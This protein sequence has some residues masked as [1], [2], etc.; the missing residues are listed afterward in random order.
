LKT[1]AVLAAILAIAIV[2]CAARLD[3]T[4]AYFASHSSGF[5]PSCLSF[6][7]STRASD[8]GFTPVITL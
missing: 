1:D 6:T 3:R 2:A 7:A 5:T 4:T 8:R